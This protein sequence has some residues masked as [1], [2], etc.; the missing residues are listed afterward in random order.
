MHFRQEGIS[1]PHWNS[2]DKLL[3]G[4]RAFTLLVRIIPELVFYLNVSFLAGH[5][6][7]PR[8]GM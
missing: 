5:T 8:L 6:A 7:K 3:A 1:S 2:I 4:V